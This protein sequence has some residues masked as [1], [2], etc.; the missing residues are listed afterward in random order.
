MKLVRKEAMLDPPV[1][2][3]CLALEHKAQASALQ[4]AP[5]R[6]LQHQHVHALLAPQRAAS[7]GA[8]AGA[9]C[10]FNTRSWLKLVL[11]LLTLAT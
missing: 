7:K 8:L 1:R 9:T 2:T 4:H 11:C 3:L 5:Q 6:Q 10:M